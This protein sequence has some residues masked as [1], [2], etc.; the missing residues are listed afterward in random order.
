LNGGTA[1]TGDHRGAEADSDTYLWDFFVSCAPEDTSWGEWIA[2]T[3]QEVG[4]RVYAEAWELVAGRNM[5][6]VLDEGLRG[7]RRT[8][9]VLTQ[10]YLDDDRVQAAWGAAWLD[11]ARRVTR[12]LVPIRTA[13]CTPRG[14]L[15][16]VAHI[17]LAGLPETVARQRLV[18]E[19]R[20]SLEG[21]RRR[22]RTPR[23]PDEKARG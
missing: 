11:D 2:G 3:L 8:L 15:G 14:L 7:S 4:Y 12:K 20:A 13:E 21:R 9:A 23:L 6:S 18:D 19:V 17:D 1:E 22:A 5:V 10:A 16:S